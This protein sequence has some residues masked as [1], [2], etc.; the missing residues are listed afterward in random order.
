M[1]EE[2]AVVV[3]E[4]EERLAEARLTRGNGCSPAP[5]LRGGLYWPYEEEEVGKLS[6]EVGVEAG[7]SR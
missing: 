2:A 1:G 4:G 5:V 3:V 6:R 7:G